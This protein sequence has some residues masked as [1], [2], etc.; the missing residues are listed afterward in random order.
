MN[1]PQT[2]AAVVGITVA[3]FTGFV[4][5]VRFTVFIPL[6]EKLDRITTQL[7]SH[8]HDEDGAVTVPVVNGA[9][10]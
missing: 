9:K 2:I 4:A 8:S 3:V 6:A 7:A 5:A 1:D 10:R